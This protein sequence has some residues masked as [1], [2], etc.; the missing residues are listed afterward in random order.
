VLFFDD[1]KTRR[2]IL[3]TGNRCTVSMCVFIGCALIVQAPRR[4]WTFKIGNVDFT[5]LI[6]H[7]KSEVR[8]IVWVPE[9]KT[10]L[11]PSSEEKPS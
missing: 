8:R 3:I 11:H 1:R 2:E 5:H 9:R 4:M 7:V 10:R 6:L